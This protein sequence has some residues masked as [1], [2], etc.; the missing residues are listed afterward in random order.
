MPSRNSFLTTGLP[1]VL[2]KSISQY[3]PQEKELFVIRTHAY[4]SYSRYRITD[5]PFKLSLILIFRKSRQIKQKGAREEIG[6][7]RWRRTQNATLGTHVDKSVSVWTDALRRFCR[8][9]S[10]KPN[11]SSPSAKL[12]SIGSFFLFFAHVFFWRDI[13]KL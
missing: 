13:L 11:L 7:F 3:W 4:T 9:Q 5:R 8:R 1:K 12:H 6:K 2:I 10:L